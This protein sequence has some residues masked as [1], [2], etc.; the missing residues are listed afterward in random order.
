MVKRTNYEASTLDDLM[1]LVLQ[2]LIAETTT[3]QATRG[4]FTEI[5]GASLTL[6]NPRARLSRSESKGKIFSALGELFWYLSGANDLDFIAY[7]LPKIYLPEAENGVV[8]SGYGNRL[9]RK[10]DGINQIENIIDKLKTSPTSRQAVIQIFDAQDLQ[11]RSVPCTCTLQFI[12]RNERL[13]LVVNMRSND[14]YLGLPHDVFAFTM[15][16]EIVARC[17]NVD[18]GIYKHFAGS[19]HL[20]EKNREQAKTYL[21]EGT[22]NQISMDSMPKGSPWASLERVKHL[23]SQLREAEGVP[24]PHSDLDDYWKDICHILTIFKHLKHKDLSACAETRAKL[25]SRYYDTFINAK[26][27][28]IQ[29]KNEEANETTQ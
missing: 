11:Y 17:L 18:L 8:N 1:E 3:V 28:E 15:L 6:D 20:Y 21:S 25:K 24:Q 7:Y 16:Q 27:A 5:I 22:Q 14:A 12:L 10:I 19:L 29:D 2:D 13:S 9:F 4:T 26:I 23:E